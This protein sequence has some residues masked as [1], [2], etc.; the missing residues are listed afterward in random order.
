MALQVTIKYF[1]TQYLKAL[2]L[3][4]RLDKPACNRHK[5]R[6]V[7]WGANASRKILTEKEK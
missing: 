2:E 1:T 7:E 6:L 4:G 3:I 5:G